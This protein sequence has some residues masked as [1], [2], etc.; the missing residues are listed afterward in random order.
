M[1]SQQHPTPAAG[2]T[3]ADL[4]REARARLVEED[5]EGAVELLARAIGVDRSLPEA[6]SLLGEALEGL[7]RWREVLRAYEQAVHLRPEDA[8][9][10]KNLGRALVRVGR[11]EESV[12][13]FRRASDLEPRS[14]ECQELLGLVYQATERPADARKAY[15]RAIDLD[16]GRASAHHHLGLLLAEG[17]QLPSALEQLETAAQLEP[18][19]ATYHREFARVALRARDGGR[20]RRAAG[21]ALRLAPVHTVALVDY[22]GFISEEK[23]ALQD[24][25]LAARF[26]SGMQGLGSRSWKGFPI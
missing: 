13:R 22:E 17:D 20:A 4:V 5:R 19:H 2:P 7:G 16:P 11:V 23:V 25:H 14:A 26:R 24:H 6:W 21:E 12:R 8:E 10:H 15:R 3:P 1:S 18:E 9:A